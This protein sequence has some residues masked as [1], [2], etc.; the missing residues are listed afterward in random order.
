MIILTDCFLSKLHHWQF[1]EGLVERQPDIF[2]CRDA[3]CPPW[4]VC[5]WHRSIACYCILHIETCRPFS[6]PQY[7][8]SLLS[9]SLPAQPSNKTRHAAPLT[10]YGLVKFMKPINPYVYVDESHLNRISNI[11]LFRRDQGILNAMNHSAYH[12]GIF[13]SE[14]YIQSHLYVKILWTAL[15]FCN[16]L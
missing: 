5:Q 1:L 8:K 12:I 3:G 7:I 4:D 11:T 13:Q 2:A 10:G 16:G 15:S 14:R 9:Y 6:V